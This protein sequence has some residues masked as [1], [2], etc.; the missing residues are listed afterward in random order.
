VFRLRSIGLIRRQ[1]SLILKWAFGAS[2]FGYVVVTKLGGG[3]SAAV[4]P[5]LFVLW[6]MAA[7]FLAIGASSRVRRWALVEENGRLRLWEFW[8]VGVHALI[9]ALICTSVVGGS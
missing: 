5:F 9:M 2:V 8:F 6:P 7:L 3:P 4:F 1:L